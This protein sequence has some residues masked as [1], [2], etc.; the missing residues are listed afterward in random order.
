MAGSFTFSFLSCKQATYET[1]TMA[2]SFKQKFN[3]LAVLINKE[4]TAT[5]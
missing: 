1:Y 3:S 4:L 5:S 2:G